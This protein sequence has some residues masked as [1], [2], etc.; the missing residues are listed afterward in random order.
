MYSFVFVNAQQTLKF[1]NK[2]KYFTISMQ[3]L[4]RLL[5]YE[6]AIVRI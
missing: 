4:N 1:I 3:F 5:R 2:Y 6:I